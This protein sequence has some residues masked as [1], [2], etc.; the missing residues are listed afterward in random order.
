[1]SDGE[2]IQ[3]DLTSVVFYILNLVGL[4]YL[5]ALGV[6]AGSFYFSLGLMFVAFLFLIYFT[7]GRESEIFKKIPIKSTSVKG[8]QMFVLGFLVVVILKL[9]GVVTQNFL[10]PKFMFSQQ[11]FDIYKIG[12]S[13]FWDFFI[14]SFSASIMEE[15]VF[16]FVFVAAGILIA[17]WIRQTWDIDFG[18]P[19]NFYFQIL[20]GSIFSII[21][22]VFF[23][24]FNPTYT[25]G[26]FII[27][28]IFRFVMN[29]VIWTFGS[30]TFGIG[31]HLANNMFAL[32]LSIIIGALFGT[33][34]GWFL[35]FIFIGLLYNTIRK[36]R[37]IDES[38]GLGDI[39]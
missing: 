16:G 4:F 9:F 8:T 5:V 3:Y 32:S 23:H 2:G 6:E 14:T 28:G 31:F 26:M 27:A 36:W 34:F 37:D 22:F 12:E 30:I 13:R 35:I 17:Y 7:V 11:L 25:T 29:I 10:S 20:I 19:G 38:I 33:A 15:L 18:D 24:Q 21:M 39:F 1:M